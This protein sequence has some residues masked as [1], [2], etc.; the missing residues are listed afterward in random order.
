MRSRLLLA[1]V[2]AAAVSITAQTTPSASAEPCPDIAVAFA[3]ATGEFPGVGSVG[4]AFVDALRMQAGG[5]TVGVHGVNYPASNNFAGGPEFTRNI[6]DGVRDEA[7]HVR[8]VIAACPDTRMVLGGFSQGAAVTAFVTSDV[9]PADAPPDYVPS[10]LP[11][12]IADHIAAVVLF[13]KPS[14]GSLV[15]YGV[16]AVDIGPPYDARALV[17]CAPGDMVCSG[18]P[19]A[20]QT[21]AH[22]S[23]IMNGMVAEGAAFAVSRL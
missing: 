15:K 13:G 6:V 16:P 17:L 19:A 18:D 10:P 20:W 11:P 2:A 22:N 9:V 1:L 23:Y 12:E 14:G 4:Q 21:T 5:R 3:R 8:G 7:N